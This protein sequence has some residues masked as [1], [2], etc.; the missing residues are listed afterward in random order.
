LTLFFY[1]HVFLVGLFSIF[2]WFP[3]QAAIQRIVP[4]IIRK[5]PHDP[6][7]FTQGLAIANNE[8]YE[9]TGLYGYSRLRVVD[10]KNGDV[11]SS[12][13]LPATFFAEGL[14]ILDQEVIQLTWR[15]QQALIYQRKPLQLLSKLFYAGEGWGLCR[16]K[17]T[18]WMSDGTSTLTQRDPKTF[19]VLH[20][21]T[22]KLNGYPLINLN[23]LE[24]AN[25]F[26]Y[27]NIWGKDE[28]VKIDV[29]TGEVIAIID[30]S[31]LLTP[32]EKK[33]RKPDHVLNGIAFHPTTQTFYVTGK[34]WP[35]IFEVKF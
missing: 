7:A 26:I 19:Q 11:L 4:Q 34:N 24:C 35:W 32:T 22:V 17:N 10:L 27:A 31:Y 18:V 1:C 15:E 13:S 29:M 3:I 5:I 6:S 33:Q 28:I 9:S 20:T 16:E 12:F 23:D 25:N 8:L 2:C 30:A 21:L 14:A